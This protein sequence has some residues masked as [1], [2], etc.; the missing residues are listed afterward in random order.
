MGALLSMMSYK[1]KQIISSF[2]SS[3]DDDKDDKKE[4]LVFISFHDHK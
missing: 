2:P 3:D 4:N 1:Y